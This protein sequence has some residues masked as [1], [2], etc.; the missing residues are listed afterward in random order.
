M[1]GSSTEVCPVCGQP[2]NC[3]DCNHESAPRLLQVGDRIELVEMGREKDGRPDPC[4]M[5][6]GSKGTVRRVHK[7]WDDKHQISVDWDPEIKRSLHLVVPPDRY[8]IIE[9]VMD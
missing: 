9:R 6:P 5:E 7:L 8:R 1:A 2:D 3:C 4:P